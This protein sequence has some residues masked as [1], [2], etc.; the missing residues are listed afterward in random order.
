MIYIAKV[1]VCIVKWLYRITAFYVMTPVFL[2][3]LPV[4]FLFNIGYHFYSYSISD[5]RKPDYT[6]FFPVSAF[7][8][9]VFMLLRF[10]LYDKYL[11][12]GLNEH[13]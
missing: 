1:I 2:F 4:E 8:F 11:D 5:K 13:L 10:D 9:F 6:Y 7:I 12:G 3:V